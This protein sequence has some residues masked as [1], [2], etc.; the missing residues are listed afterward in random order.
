MFS[1]LLYKI[2]LILLI[3]N[4]YQIPFKTKLHPSFQK[5]LFEKTKTERRGNFENENEVRNYSFLKYHHNC[6]F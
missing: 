1:I 5:K 6:Y 4:S 2:E 3:E